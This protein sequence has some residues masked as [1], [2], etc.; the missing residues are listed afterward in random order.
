[1]AV[2]A[3]ANNIKVV[4]ASVLPASSYSWS[5]SVEPIDK[6]SA[7]NDLIKTYAEKNNIVYLDYYSPMVNK[8]KGLIKI[9]G[10]D[11]VHPNSKGYEIME[12]LVKNAINEALKN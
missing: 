9:L 6:I 12:P 7:L 2:L 10:R 5:P 1:M 11:T 4:L 8:D 3:K